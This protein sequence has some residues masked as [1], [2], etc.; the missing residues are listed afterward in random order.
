MNASRILQ[1]DQ[2]KLNTT[3]R[4]IDADLVKTL[5][6]CIDPRTLE[7]CAEELDRDPSRPKLYAQAL[8]A[9][10][11]NQKVAVKIATSISRVDQPGGADA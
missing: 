3:A 11:A 10:A 6:G 9:M 7:L 2:G 5:L 8:R 4:P 1:L